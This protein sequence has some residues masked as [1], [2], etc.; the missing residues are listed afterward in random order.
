MLIR[1]VSGN[2]GQLVVTCLLF[3]SHRGLS[4]PYDFTD[5]R[6]LLQG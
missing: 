3:H 4:L 1:T 5:P 6:S 2:L